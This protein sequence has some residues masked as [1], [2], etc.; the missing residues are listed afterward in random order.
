M[1]SRMGRAESSD[2][3]INDRD[4][5]S[6]LTVAAL[7]LTRLFAALLYHV[8]PRDP[9]AFGATLVVNGYGVVRSAFRPSLARNADRSCARFENG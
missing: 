8:S 1:A 4:I 5:T 3:T 6:P 2:E 9:L 7:L